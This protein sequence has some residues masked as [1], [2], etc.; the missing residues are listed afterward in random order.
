VPLRKT[1]E[2]CEAELA[3][4][5]GKDREHAARLATVKLE[6]STPTD[7]LRPGIASLALLIVAAV[8]VALLV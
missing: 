4:L 2:Q 8:L 1:R 6:P 7:A 5:D 3:E